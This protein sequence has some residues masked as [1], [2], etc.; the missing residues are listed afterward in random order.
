MASGSHRCSRTETQSTTSSD[1]SWNLGQSVGQHSLDGD[2]ATITL[3]IIRERDID[4]HRVVDLGKD[5][6]YERRVKAAAEV[7]DAFA[8]KASHVAP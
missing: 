7:A 1:P 6:P 4:E 5:A 2:D 8:G 3:Q